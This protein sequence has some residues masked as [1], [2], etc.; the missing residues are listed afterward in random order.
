MAPNGERVS[1]L[2]ITGWREFPLRDRLS[3]DLG[4]PVAVDNDAKALALAEHWVGAAQGVDHFMAMVVSTGVGGGIVLDGR[5]LHGRRANAGH[6]GHVIVEPDG[7]QCACGARG[8]LEA[9]ISGPAIE[10]RTSAP[11]A[12]AS[13]HERRRAGRLLGRAV[14][15]VVNLLDLD[16]VL[17]GGS[18]ALGF[19]VPF[20]DAANDELAARSCLDFAR[21]ARIAPVG[22]GADAPLVG[23]AAVARAAMPAGGNPV[24]AER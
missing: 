4:L 21:G 6:V 7:A 2:N 24:E 3:A 15:S 22:L 5:L 13:D 8:C 17:V 18:V 14:G 12:A 20:F 10:R 19:D 1:P 23:A 11:A 9:E 16:L